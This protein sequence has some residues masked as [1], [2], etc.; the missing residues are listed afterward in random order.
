M[1]VPSTIDDPVTWKSGGLPSTLTVQNGDLI[2]SE[3]FQLQGFSLGLTEIWKDDA[4]VLAGDFSARAVV[5]VSAPHVF[6]GLFGRGQD[7]SGDGGAYFC[8]IR[9][10]GLITVGSFTGETLTLETTLDVVNNDVV[11][12][13][14]A[15]GDE[16]T[17]SAWLA[18]APRP[19]DAPTITFTDVDGAGRP[20]GFCGQSFGAGGNDATGAT[21]TF[22]SFRAADEPISG[23]LRFLRGDCNDDGSVDIADVICLVNGR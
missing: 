19:D 23:E 4:R 11:L 15:F 6:A 8:N 14:D 7:E 21:A 3:P 18:G 22:R 5:R 17:A 13:L 12:Q 16:V 20:A 9:G 10:S 2:L 1:T